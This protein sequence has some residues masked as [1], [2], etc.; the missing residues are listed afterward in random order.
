MHK[1]G[2][3]VTQ[4]ERID[5]CD[6]L[7][8]RLSRVGIDYLYQLGENRVRFYADSE[9]RGTLP[10][11][12]LVFGRYKTTHKIPPDNTALTSSHVAQQVKGLAVM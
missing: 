1:D 4:R 8:S 9:S 11:V 2:D 10:D 12:D 3:T 7:Q 5:I 6:S